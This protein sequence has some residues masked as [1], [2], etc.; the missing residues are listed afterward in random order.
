MKVEDVYVEMDNSWKLKT[1]QNIDQQNNQ[2]SIVSIE[3]LVKK[4]ELENVSKWVVEKEPAALEKDEDQKIMSANQSCL[5]QIWKGI[6]AI[7]VLKQTSFKAEKL[8]KTDRF[9][10]L[11]LVINE[12]GRRVLWGVGGGG[13]GANLTTSLTF[14]FT[15]LVRWNAF[16]TG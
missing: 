2:F 13:G 12:W 1:W 9:C 6:I 3:K 7:L 14:P 11:R 5:L 10:K 8:V 16:P 15:A 4:L